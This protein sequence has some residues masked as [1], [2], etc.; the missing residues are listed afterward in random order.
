MS[1]ATWRPSPN[2]F[3]YAADLLDPPAWE[4]QDR[5]PLEPHQEPPEGDW[6]AW[7]LEGGRGSGKT[8]ACSRYF[9]K[10][11]REHPGHRGRIIAPTFGDA[12]ESCITGPSGLKAIDPDVSWHSSDPGGAKV[13]WPNGSEALVIGTHSPLDIERL[14][15]GGNRHI[16][17]W[18]EVAANRQLGG[19][20][21]DGGAWEQAQLGLRLGDHPHSIGST[22]P[23]NTRAWRDL[24]KAEGTVLT[25]ATM[26]DNPHL[27][28]SWKRR[29]QALYAG[30]RLA[31]QEI[32]GELLEDVE[33]ALWTA[34][35]IDLG[36]VH[37]HPDL[38]RVVVAVDPSG[39][40]T[41]GHDDQGIVV[42]G[43][44]V[45]GHAYVL[46]DRTCRLS[47]D[48]WG[49]RAVQAYIDHRADAILWEANYGGDMV[50]SNIRAAA[51]ALGVEVNT[52]KVTASRGKQLRAQPVAAL[53]GDPEDL[54]H[55]I[56]RAHHVGSFPELE[57][58]Q[59]MWT[60]ESGES[61]DRLDALTMCLT[62]LMLG[63]DLE[64]RIIEWS[65]PVTI[66]A[67]L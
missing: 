66:G 61:P 67:D 32:G 8:E 22:T 58:Q 64:D 7:F 21:V 5:P 6:D 57:E 49:R 41:E 4:P 26:D 52:E 59:T 24:R 23:R 36:R 18:E 19:R 17:W 13:R 45:N 29:I 38:V 28:D 46:D 12:V 56:P 15:A 20:G 1:V 53:Y 31:R 3:A 39:G 48:G 9:A 11:M 47:P 30:T 25:H 2:P 62:D 40:S 63:E 43:K 60:P 65:D 34:A 42:A 14:R 33:G 37:E 51:R 27:P 54:D 50:V 10:W 55:S 44:G 35:L 16:D